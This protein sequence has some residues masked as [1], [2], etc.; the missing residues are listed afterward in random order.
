MFSTVRSRTTLCLPYWNC[1]T[2]NT[3]SNS[4]QGTSN[5]ELSQTKGAA[6]NGLPNE[7][8][9]RCR[10]DVFA[11]SKEITCV[12]ARKSTDKC[13]KNERSYNNT[14]DGSIV[15]FFGSCGVRCVDFRECFGP[16]I[17]LGTDISSE[18]DACVEEIITDNRPPTPAW[19]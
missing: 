15:R 14:L 18:Q 11:T 8:Q 10:K 5:D 4:N 2:Q 1:S 6:A 3:N 17:E 12:H 16:V 9:C 13:T 7:S 19:L